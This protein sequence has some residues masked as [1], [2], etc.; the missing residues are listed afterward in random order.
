MEHVK[1]SGQYLENPPTGQ[2]NVILLLAGGG[3]AAEPTTTLGAFGATYGMKKLFT[4]NAG[5]RL[6]LSS[7]GMKT[8]SPAM[9]RIIESMAKT[10]ALDEENK[11]E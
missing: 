2:R 10:L 4:S 5:K 6:L 3:A 9:E 8:G 7:S 1:R 11:N